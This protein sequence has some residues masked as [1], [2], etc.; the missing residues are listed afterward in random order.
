MLLT[1]IVHVSADATRQCSGPNTGKI[2]NCSASELAHPGP[3]RAGECIN[4]RCFCSLLQKPEQATCLR[5]SAWCWFQNIIVLWFDSVIV[6]GKKL[7]RVYVKQLH[8]LYLPSCV[9]GGI[10]GL[11]I[12]QIVQA[13]DVEFYYW[14][15]VYWTS[16]WESL[17]GFLI[18]IVFAS[19]FLGTPV[20]NVKRFGARQGQT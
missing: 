5:S 11:T 4:D 8:F 20:P 14:M 1:T 19:L 7:T 15:S 16:G 2:Y 10:Y 9:I 6:T 13:A 18:N 17:P 3:S 12:L